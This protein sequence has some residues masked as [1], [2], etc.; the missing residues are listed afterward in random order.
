MALSASYALLC[1]KEKTSWK[2]M[3]HLQRTHDVFLYLPYY[4]APPIRVPPHATFKFTSLTLTK[5]S[6]LQRVCVRAHGGGNLIHSLYCDALV[7]L[8][9]AIDPQNHIFLNKTRFTKPGLVP[10]SFA[11]FSYRPSNLWLSWQLV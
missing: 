9:L 3:F 10:T 4:K 6:L 11:I 2:K 5:I 7:F 1:I 8:L